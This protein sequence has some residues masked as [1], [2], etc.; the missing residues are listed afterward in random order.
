MTPQNKN[1]SSLL[2]SK[3]KA[4]TSPYR[5]SRHFLVLDTLL[6]KISRKSQSRVDE[7]SSFVF[8]SNCNLSLSIRDVSFAE[9]TARTI[10]KETRDG[11]K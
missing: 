9:V 6:K 11:Q 3:K 2:L 4:L 10:T 1:N 8:S 5:S 7:R